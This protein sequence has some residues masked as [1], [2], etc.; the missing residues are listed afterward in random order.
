MCTRAPLKREYL[1]DAVVFRKSCAELIQSLPS[2]YLSPAR[3]NGI[4][5]HE[6]VKTRQLHPTGGDANTFNL[7]VAM[8][9]IPASCDYDI[10]LMNITLVNESTP[11]M[12]VWVGST[13]TLFSHSTPIL[14]LSFLSPPSLLPLSSLFSSLSP[15]SFLLAIDAP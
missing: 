6:I 1:C 9:I 12:L 5:L 3:P 14:F 15:T 11:G 7:T 8:E 2:Q 13:I 10:P 4:A